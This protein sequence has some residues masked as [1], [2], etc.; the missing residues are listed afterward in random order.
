MLDGRPPEYADLVNLPYTRMVI[1][2]AMRL[3]P[4]AWGFSRQALADDEL[5]GFHLPRGWLA[6]VIPYVL[7]RLP[8]FWQDPDAFDPER[9]SAGTQR[10]SA[11]IRLPAVRRRTTTVHRQ[12]IRADRSATR[13]LRHSRNAIGFTS[14]RGHRVEPWPLITLRPRFGMPMIIERRAPSSTHTRAGGVTVD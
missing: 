11:E 1:D 14:C 10:R 3:Y 9:F 12:P 5:G 13:S 6:F 7:H 8:A 4:P 2:E